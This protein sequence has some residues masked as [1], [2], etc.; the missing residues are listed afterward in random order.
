MKAFVRDSGLSL[1]AGDDVAATQVE[2]LVLVLY[3]LVPFAIP[4]LIWPL[5]VAVIGRVLGFE[6]SSTAD[7]AVWAI[8]GATAILAVISVATPSLRAW[9]PAAV[10]IRGSL[11]LSRVTLA[12]VAF[13]PATVSFIGIAIAYWPSSTVFVASVTAGIIALVLELR[14]SRSRLMRREVS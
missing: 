14:T 12:I 11:A 2:R 6:G 1:L 4:G 13:P 8:A 7:L 10:L 5:A 9:R 3:G